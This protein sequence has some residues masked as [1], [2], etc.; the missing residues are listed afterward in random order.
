V[1]EVLLLLLL[2]IMMMPLTMKFIKKMRLNRSSANWT[3]TT[4]NLM[5]WT[6]LFIDYQE[7]KGR[8][9]Q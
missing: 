9:T 6:D 5:K 8:N 7:E 2:L 1:A 3:D 4:K